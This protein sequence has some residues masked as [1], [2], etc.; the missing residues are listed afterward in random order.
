MR[1][2]VP[3][4]HRQTPPRVA[5]L[6]RRSGEGSDPIVQRDELGSEPLELTLDLLDREIRLRSVSPFGSLKLQSK[7]ALR[8][9][10]TLLVGHEGRELRLFGLERLQR[11]ELLLQVSQHQGSAPAVQRLGDGDVGEDV[12]SHVE[13]PRTSEAQV[14]FDRVGVAA[15]IDLAVLERAGHRSEHS[16]FV[17]HLEEGVLLREEAGFAGRD[18]DE[19]ENI[20]P[21]HAVGQIP[22]DGVGH[23]G[24]GEKP[25]GVGDQQQLLAGMFQVEQGEREIGIELDEGVGIRGNFGFQ[26]AEEVCLVHGGVHLVVEVGVAMV[27]GESSRV[28]QIDGLQ[29]KACL[30]QREKGVHE[31]PALVCH[32]HGPAA[33]DSPLIFEVEHLGAVASPLDVAEAVGLHQVPL[34]AIDDEPLRGEFRIEA[35]LPDGPAELVQL[36]LGVLV[37]AFFPHVDLVVD[38]RVVHVEAHRLDGPQVEGSVAENASS[39]R[40]GRG[41]CAIA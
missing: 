1:L 9:F 5:E 15:Q 25:A 29:K 28:G 20:P 8:P 36:P 32:V 24:L 22:I 26:A 16:V 38:Q 6:A 27:L 13:N 34:D 31:E 37:R 23:H 11:L 10:E 30:G 7:L 41:D 12:V 19:I 3:R 39:R 14:R 40:R 2:V 21:A 4:S 35:Q 18:D 17:H 33:V